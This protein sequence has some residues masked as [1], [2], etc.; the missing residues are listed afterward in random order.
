MKKPTHKMFLED[1]QEAMSKIERYTSGLTY[2]T[3]VNNEMAVDAVIRNLA[4]IGEASRNI[5]DSVRE[6][7]TDIQW[8]RMVGLRNIVIHQYFSV[9]LSIIWKIIT[10]NLPETKP[11]IAEMLEH[12]DE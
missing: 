8:G 9:D 5:P 12:F 2:Q 7:Y 11:Q 10:E 1:I 3:F 6:K 4:V